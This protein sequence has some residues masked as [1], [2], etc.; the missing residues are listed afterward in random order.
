MNKFIAWL[1]SQ[2]RRQDE[3]GVVAVALLH[4][5]EIVGAPKH[6]QGMLNLLR[7]VLPGSTHEVE[8]MFAHAYDE[9]WLTV[10]PR[11]WTQWGADGHLDPTKL[12]PAVIH[13]RI[14]GA[15]PEE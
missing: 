15:P 13:S 5:C 2:S 9:W 10:N 4:E 8:R 14:A 7:G 6:W 3:I 11:H 12:T 1:Q